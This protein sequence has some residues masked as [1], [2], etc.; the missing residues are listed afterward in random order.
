[1]LRAT[2]KTYQLQSD[3]DEKITIYDASNRTHIKELQKNSKMKGTLKFEDNH[4]IQIFKSSNDEGYG[5]GVTASLEQG[6]KKGTLITT[7]DGE[8]T[9]QRELTE[10]QEKFAFGIS[11]RENWIILADKTGN[12]SRF[13][14]HS[15]TV[16]NVNVVEKKLPDG[17]KEIQ[18]IAA[19]DITPGKQ[20]LIDY[21]NKYEFDKE[22][23]LCVYQNAMTRLELFQYYSNFYLTDPILLT[24]EVKATLDI[25]DYP[26]TH[27]LVPRIYQYDHQAPSNQNLP[28]LLATSTT[29]DRLLVHEK[30]PY[31]TPLM[32]ACA[33]KDG[34]RLNNILKNQVDIFAK[35]STGLTALAIAAKMIRD[36]KDFDIYIPLLD[37]IQAKLNNTTNKLKKRKSRKVEA[38]NLFKKYIQENIIDNQIM[39]QCIENRYKLTKRKKQRTKIKLIQKQQGSPDQ[40]DQKELKPEEKAQLGSTT[41]ITHLLLAKDPVTSKEIIKDSEIETKDPAPKKPRSKKKKQNHSAKTEADMSIFACNSNLFRAIHKEKILSKRQ[42][43][44]DYYPKSPTH[45]DLEFG[46]YDPRKT[47][48]EILFGAKRFSSPLRPAPQLPPWSINNGFPSSTLNTNSLFYPPP[49]FPPYFPGVSIP[50]LPPSPH[51]LNVEMH[52]SLERGNV[53]VNP[54]AKT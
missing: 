11:G 54:H 24:T 42:E 21:G 20:L 49:I 29:E 36:P 30:Q 41:N 14:N 9:Q 38:S 22:R 28:I 5:F 50:L 40:N 31:I 43:E 19:E 23:Y 7:Y 51:S 3:A 16:N 27:V 26:A 46:Q 25:E 39:L 17:K 2:H 33:N 53:I 47:N 34:R 37:A 13:F 32:L 15:S 18:F 1:M 48:E 35:T 52:P 4:Q 6:I 45:I 44:E 10:S 8:R 12:F